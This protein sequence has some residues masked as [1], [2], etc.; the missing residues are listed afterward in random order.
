MWFFLIS[1]IISLAASIGVNSAF[2]RYSQVR[3]SRGITGAQAA[4]QMLDDHGLYQ[5]QITRCA[6]ELT[7]HYDPRTN[8]IALSEAVYD[9]PTVAAV[10]VAMHEAG[11][12]VQHAEQYA[13]VKIR[14]AIVGVTNFASTASYFLILLGLIFG[15]GTILIDLGIILFC[16]VLFFQLVTLPVEFN[17]S[18]RAVRTIRDTLLLDE[19]ERKGVSNVLRAAAMTYVAAL[20]VSA[21]QLLRLL[22]IRNNRR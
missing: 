21:L 19:D 17:A 1:M 2:K 5:V 6:G 10:G 12:A 15:Q 4:R 11:H 7:D 9:Q 16:V 3:N 8:T 13:P 22:A 14:S 18:G 20:A